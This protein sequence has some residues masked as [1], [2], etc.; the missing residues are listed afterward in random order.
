MSGNDSKQR[1]KLLHLLRI[2]LEESDDEHGL[3][4]PQ[5]I[6]Q[7]S[8]RGVSAE[9]KAVYRDIEALR[10]YGFEIVTL[11]RRPVQYALVNRLFSHAE[12]LLLVD[13]VQSSRFLTKSKSEALIKSLRTLASKRYAADLAPHVHVEGRIKM[14]NESVFTNVDII[15]KAMATKKKIS[16]RYFRYDENKA[17]QVQ[18]EGARYEETPVVLTYA[19]DC[20][21]LVAYNDKHGDLTTYRLDRMQQLMVSD[22]PA[23]RND[24]IASFNIAT[25]QARMFGM[26]RG[27]AVRATLR[28]HAD[29]MGALIDKFGRD[30]ETMPIEDGWARAYVHVMDSPTFFGWIAQFGDRM[31]IEAPEKLRM[32]YCD[33]L[34]HVLKSYEA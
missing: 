31:V 11:P 26:F 25:Y 18:R 30:V 32:A 16:F 20:Y 3:T 12:L 13:A 19:D 1:V 17:Q 23:T 8:A 29:C 28:V 9:R 2:L 14:Q 15:R 4:M 27:E 34:H 7:L 22:A 10:G 24:R 6:D 21:Y 5:L 33:H